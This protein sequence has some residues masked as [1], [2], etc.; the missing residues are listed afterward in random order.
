MRESCVLGLCVEIDE[1]GVIEAE[2]LEVAGVETELDSGIPLFRLL[3][4][5]SGYKSCSAC[6]QDPH[7]RFHQ[8]LI[9]HSELCFEIL[10]HPH[11]SPKTLRR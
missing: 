10:S 3:Y 9:L 2:E 7:Y 8:A 6:C 5:E 1:V 11:Y 4:M